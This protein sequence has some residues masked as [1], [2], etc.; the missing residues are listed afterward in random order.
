MRSPVPEVRPQLVV[1]VLPSGRRDT[2]P[3][4]VVEDNA[5]NQAVAK[6]L[7]KR[8]GY[9]VEVASSGAEALEMLGR[10]AYALILMDCQMPEMDGFEVTRRIRSGTA[11]AL[12]PSVP[13]IALTANAMHGDRELCLQAGMDDHVP[14]P[15]DSRLLGEAITRWLGARTAV[16]VA[17]ESSAGSTAASARSTT[18]SVESGNPGGEAG[19][20]VV[21]MVFDRENFL[22]RVMGDE[23]LATMVLNGFREDLPRLLG[24]LETALETGDLSKATLQAHTIKGSAANVGAEA[25]R[26][27]AGRMEEDGRRGDLGAMR[28]ALAVLRTQCARFEETLGHESTDCRR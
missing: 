24:A 18:L 6:G 3:L 17:E 2:R 14:K 23:E 8:L 1:E 21:G 28:G 20:E 26:G 5:V 16:P 15:V 11:G 22:R 13:I 4:L 27:V 9:T 10:N 25:L 12:D 7:L 19:G